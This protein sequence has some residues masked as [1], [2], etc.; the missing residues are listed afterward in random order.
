MTGTTGDWS[1]N[2][3]YDSESGKASITGER[4]FTPDKPSAGNPVTLTVK[5]QFT[6]MAKTVDA[7]E[8]VQAAVQLGVGG[9]FQVW[10]KKKLGVVSGGVGELGWLDVEAEGVV[11]RAG[12]EYTFR[13]RIDY[14]TRLYTVSVQ[15]A[16]GGFTPL[17]ANGETSFA[18]A[19][20][21]TCLSS[22]RF[23]GG[24]VL[25][26]IKGDYAKG[27]GVVIR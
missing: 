21:A 22:V 5:M 24:G 25:T 3:D 12:V 16:G 20:D 13:F 17:G 10:T 6:D 19:S 23:K 9:L 4:T 15:N 14:R 2:V 18:L 7:P 27:L 8:G 11:P 26:S 1:Q